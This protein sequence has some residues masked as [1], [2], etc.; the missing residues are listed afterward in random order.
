MEHRTVGSET[1][2]C[3]V[4]GLR[5]EDE[6]AAGEADGP[7]CWWMVTIGIVVL[8]GVIAAVVIFSGA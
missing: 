6:E 5:A 1:K 8:F 2:N 3:S 4:A 7:S